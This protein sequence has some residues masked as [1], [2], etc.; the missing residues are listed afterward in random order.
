MRWGTGKTPNPRFG[1]VAW[2]KVF[3]FLPKH[4]EDKRWVWFE[5]YLEKREYGYNHNFGYDRWNLRGKYSQESKEWFDNVLT[6]EE[7]EKKEFIRKS[8][9][10]LHN[11]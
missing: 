1:D 6:E 5:S 8:I 11:E 2:C 9:E 7:R 10:E 4:C 3:A